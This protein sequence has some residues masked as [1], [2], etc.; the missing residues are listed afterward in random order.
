M[1]NKAKKAICR[2]ED[3]GNEASVEQFFV[4]RLLKRLGWADS[5]IKT[6]ESISELSVNLGRKKMPYKP[7]YALSYRRKVRFVIDAKSTKENLDSWVGQCSSYCLLINQGYKDNPVQYF[8]LTNGLK[9]MLYRWDSAK[10]ILTL[11]LSDMNNG[12]KAF[13]TLAEYLSPRSFNATHPAGLSSEIEEERIVLKQIGP[14]AVNKLFGS[15]HSYIYKHEHLS[16]GAAFTEFVKVIFLKMTSDKEAHECDEG[17]ETDEGYSVPVSRAKF[18][19]QWIKKAEETTPNPVNTILFAKLVK[20]FEDLIAQKK[21]KRIFEPNEKIRL[22]AGTIKELVKRFEEVDLHL[23]EDDLNGRMFET[24]LNATLRGKSLGQYF[25]PRSIVDIAVGL[26]DLH[27]GRNVSDCSQI[28]DACCGSGGFLIGALNGMWGKVDSNASLSMKEK[29]EIKKNIAENCIWG[30]DAARDPALA[31]IA[32]MNMF[33]HGDGGSKIFQLDSLDKN[34]TV[35]EDADS[36]ELRSEKKEFRDAI[37]GRNGYFDLALTNPPFAAEYKCSEPSDL[38]LLKDYSIAH[39]PDGNGISSLR[40]TVRSSVLFIERYYDILKPGGSLIT[41][42]DDGILGGEDTSYV[43]DWIRSHFIVRAVISLPGDAFQRSQARVKTSLLFLQKKIEAAQEQPRI[44]MRYCSYVGLDSPNRERVLPSDAITAQKAKEEIT[45]IVNGYKAFLDGDPEIARLY[46]VDPKRIEN[47]MD[48]KATL[49]V[50]GRNVEKWSERGFKVRAAKDIAE[51]IWASGAA[52]ED[53]VGDLF[54]TRGD[55]KRKKVT[56]AV[57][58]YDGTIAAGDESYAEDVS[59]ESL[60]KLKKDDIV[61][62]NINAVNG[63]VAVVDSKTAGLY[64]SSEYTVIQPK[65]PLTVCALWSL[66]R[67]DTARSDL[68]LLSTGIGRTRISWDILSELK[69]P[70][71]KLESMQVIQER[72]E[73][74]AET[75]KKAAALLEE[76]SQ[77]VN[78]D[79]CNSDERALSVLTAF[80]PPK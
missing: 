3:L 78:I 38:A 79:I 2:K 43:R 51:P 47:R 58:K 68:I 60:F 13:D 29:Q 49:L 57:V 42:L 53:R 15:A 24:F 26:S 55:N 6:K 72:M 27:V 64:V 44:Y 41:V 66:I 62:S 22:S 4:D 37:S 39:R 52:C 61:L 7:D 11:S 76:V 25:T 80:K 19:S 8:V 63:A 70:V 33:L 21:K 9:T 36:L 23:I 30:I 1:N 48:V 35:E 28:I 69:L 12:S 14:S 17:Y 18:S 16:Y 5:Q 59:Y 46:S 73:E 31:R 50:A 75:R 67:S 32:R 10:P 40:G 71:P 56:F 65:D 20:N 54:Y 77:L 45:D 74:L 34:I